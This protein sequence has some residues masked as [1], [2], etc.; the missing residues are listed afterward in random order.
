MS[1]PFSSV[2]QYKAVCLVFDAIVSANY[3]ILNVRSRVPST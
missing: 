3:V 1:L 2:G